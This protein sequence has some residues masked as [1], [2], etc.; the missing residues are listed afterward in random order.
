MSAFSRHLWR[1]SRNALR[2]QKSSNPVQ[3]ALGIQGSSRY[4]NGV[5]NYAAAF[6]RDKPHVNI[7]MYLDLLFYFRKNVSDCI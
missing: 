2:Y 5:R 4:V 3:Q 1:T 7:G 6:T